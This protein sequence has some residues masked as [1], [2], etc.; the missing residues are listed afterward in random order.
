MKF[1]QIIDREA[2]DKAVNLSQDFFTKEQKK[3][4]CGD[5]FDKAFFILLILMA[6]YS[7]IT[8]KITFAICYMVLC[9]SFFITN[10]SVNKESDKKL[11]SKFVCEQYLITAPE[12]I[13]QIMVDENALSI[14]ETEIS[15]ENIISAFLYDDFVVIVSKDKT[16]AVIKCNYAERKKI[17]DTLYKNKCSIFAFDRKH[18]NLILTLKQNCKT[19]LKSVVIT[20]GYICLLCPFLELR[21]YK[22]SDLVNQ[23]YVYGVYDATENFA[24]QMSDEIDV[25][26]NIGRRLNIYCEYVVTEYN[27][28]IN[29][30]YDKK[31]GTK[32]TEIYFFDENN[33]LYMVSAGCPGE[34]DKKMISYTYSDA[35][36]HSYNDNSNFCIKQENSQPIKWSDEFMSMVKYRYSLRRY[37]VVTPGLKMKNNYTFKLKGSN[38]L[39]P[40]I[41]Y[42]FKKDNIKIT[43]NANGN[44]R[45]NTIYFVNTEQYTIDEIK[46]SF[47][48][49]ETDIN[50]YGTLKNI[51]FEELY[52]IVENFK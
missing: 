16:S 52:F 31:N 29:V 8:G 20:V 12:T 48:K 36:I 42:K 25:G 39:F 13:Y 7:C 4:K 44:N 30:C 23:K 47:N 49:Y 32:N 41:T 17:A 46:Q 33:L 9:V 5:F 19:L 15:F 18:E 21:L 38:L 40:D 34:K 27:T 43:E 26:H 22:I 28:R 3:R 1:E 6:I 10:H 2:L 50:N 11:L 14:S 24:Y 51:D 45:Y 35:M 37:S